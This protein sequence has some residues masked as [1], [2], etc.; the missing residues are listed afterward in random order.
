MIKLFKASL[1][2]NDLKLKLNNEE[3]LNYLNRYNLKIYKKK[4]KDLEIDK[5]ISKKMM[6]YIQTFLNSK[7]TQKKTVKKNKNKN[8]H[9]FIELNN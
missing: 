1:L 7:F 4:K 3:L 2:C 5:I 8:T 9:K 6:Y